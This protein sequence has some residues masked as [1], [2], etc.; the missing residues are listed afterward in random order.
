[1]TLLRRAVRLSICSNS[2]HLHH[3]MIGTKFAHYEIPS[4]LG[5]SGRRRV[6]SY[7][8][9]AGPEGTHG[10][11]KIAGRTGGE[12]VERDPA[13][14]LSLLSVG[15]LFGASLYDAVVLAPNLRGGPTG[16]EHGWLFMTRATPANLFRIA[17]PA[18]Q[19]SEVT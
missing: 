5:S 8:L 12:S 13:T 10:D 7:R 15:A 1:M 3:F 4:H 19:N 11:R 17:A 14:N 16:L 2:A 18:T 9:E 6:S